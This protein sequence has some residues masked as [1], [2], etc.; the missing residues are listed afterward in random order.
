MKF[1]LC[2]AKLLLKW[3]F[4]PL[5]NKAVLWGCAWWPADSR[6]ES[7]LQD[8]SHD[9]AFEQ[10]SFAH[11]D[12]FILPFLTQRETQEREEAEQVRLEQMRKE[13]EE[14]KEV[15]AIYTLN[16][17]NQFSAF[18]Q[19]RWFWLCWTLSCVFLYVHFLE[20]GRVGRFSTLIK[21]RPIHTNVTVLTH[22]VSVHVNH[23]TVVRH[24]DSQWNVVQQKPQAVNVQ[25]PVHPKKKKSQSKQTYSPENNY[26][27]WMRANTHVHT[28]TD[29]HTH[30]SRDT[31]THA[32]K[33]WLCEDRGA[34]AVL[35]SIVIQCSPP[36]L[37]LPVSWEPEGAARYWVTRLAQAICH[38]S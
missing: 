7:P 6:A 13:Q 32:E 15:S 3:R 19:C 5:W 34:T 22:T 20:C 11:L 9:L 4:V 2:M 16:Q 31:V 14:E 29:T 25:R 17:L 12:I 36:Q 23:F 28:H 18:M 27:M 1:S 30:R 21:L 26:C 37:C 24:T 35:H 38:L 33:Q 8:S 10:F